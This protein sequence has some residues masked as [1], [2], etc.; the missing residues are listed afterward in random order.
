MPAHTI[1]APILLPPPIY[2]APMECGFTSGD[3]VGLVYL[4]KI[5]PSIRNTIKLRMAILRV[6]RHATSC[7]DEA[8]TRLE[9]RRS[10]TKRTLPISR[11][12]NTNLLAGCDANIVKLGESSILGI[13]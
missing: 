1:F 7:R 10:R 5:Q 2:H 12:H 9:Y 13:S 4:Y 8:A 3:I 6:P 11:T